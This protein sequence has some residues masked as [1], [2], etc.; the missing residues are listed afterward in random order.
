MDNICW[1]AKFAFVN[2]G[3]IQV[4]MQIHKIITNCAGGGV[5]TKS[6]PGQ[7]HAASLFQLVYKATMK[8]DAY[9]W[10]LLLTKRKKIG[11]KWNTQGAPDATDNCSLPDRCAHTMPEDDQHSGICPVEEEIQGKKWNFQK[12]F[13]TN[14]TWWC[15]EQPSMSSSP[16]PWLVHS[17]SF[18]PHAT[19]LSFFFNT[20]DCSGANDQW[21]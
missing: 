20:P 10:K 9:R 18:R 5:S 19:P 15:D 6:S 7:T 12:I 17:V 2:L 16:V 11:S 13:Q 4:Q 14:L 3:S 1:L 8:G 21:L